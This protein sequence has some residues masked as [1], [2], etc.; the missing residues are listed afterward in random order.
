MA[1]F[2]DPL[3]DAL[4]KSGGDKHKQQQRQNKGQQFSKQAPR[5]IP[6]RLPS[7]PWGIVPRGRNCFV[8]L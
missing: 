2:A 3:I 7:P 8:H 5:P 4:I 1:G 6:S